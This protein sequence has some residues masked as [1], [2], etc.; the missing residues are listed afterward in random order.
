MILWYYQMDAIV[1]AMMVLS[2]DLYLVMMMLLMNI[3]VKTI[4]SFVMQV[5][6]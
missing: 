1:E 2:M 3:K 5:E 4:V 6:L